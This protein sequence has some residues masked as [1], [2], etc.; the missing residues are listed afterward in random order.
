MRS[1]VS[2]LEELRA[3]DEST[4]IEAKTASAIDRSVI[5]TV[6]AFANEPA[7]GGG[8]L[9][10]GVSVGPQGA[11]F[12]RSYEVTG[13]RDPDKLQSDLASQCSS[14]LS[15]PIRPQVAVESVEGRS[16]VVV[17]VPELSATDKPVYLNA[18]GLP[19]GAFRRVGSTDQEGTED[20]LI[21]LYQGRQATPTTPRCCGMPTLRTSIPRRYASTVSS[22]ARPTASPRS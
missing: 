16:V 11:L 10:L 17:F 1:A 22:G 9:L 12:G 18:L 13:V 4:T 2:L 21:A 19:R 14:A 20:D 15:R 6:C 7:L 5:E 3:L 8:Y